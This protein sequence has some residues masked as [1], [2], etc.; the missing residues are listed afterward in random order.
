MILFAIF[1]LFTGKRSGGLGVLEEATQAGMV[2]PTETTIWIN[3][4][5]W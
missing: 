4:Q 3:L 2:D 1:T 5:G